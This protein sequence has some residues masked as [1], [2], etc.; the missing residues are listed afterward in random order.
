MPGAVNIG[1]TLLHEDIK[2][3]NFNT[4][5]YTGV[6]PMGW[7][8]VRGLENAPIAGNLL[9]V[10]YNADA[11]VAEHIGYVLDETHDNKDLKNTLRS[12]D[13]KLDDVKKIRLAIFDQNGDSIKVVKEFLSNSTNTKMQADT[14]AGDPLGESLMFEKGKAVCDI[15]A[16]YSYLSR[17]FVSSGNFLSYI[18]QSICPSFLFNFICNFDGRARM[19][20]GKWDHTA[21]K[22]VSLKI[23]EIHYNL[24]PRYQRALGQVVCQS[25]SA[26]RYGAGGIP[27]ELLGAFPNPLSPSDGK[28]SM[29]AAPDWFKATGDHHEQ[30]YIYSPDGNRDIDE[31]ADG[32]VS[33]QEFANA[34]SIGYDL[35]PSFLT[36]YAQKGYI[37][38]ALQ[39][40]VC[41]VKTPLDVSWG[42]ESGNSLGERYSVKSSESGAVLFRG[43]LHGVTHQLDVSGGQEGIAETTLRFTH[44]KMPGFELPSGMI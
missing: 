33:K 28:I 30:S 23:K 10:E 6:S 39:A 12:I 26:D 32:I 37:A 4:S 36:T 11:G 18:Q 27:D 24:A 19:E 15:G 1:M 21:E 35:A 34:T 22:S 29:V 42:S 3:Q 7:G 43:L 38:T 8:Q 31:N 25:N 9:G 13:K 41:V 14:S 17:R 40:A 16:Y 20:H 2:L 44:I 5:I